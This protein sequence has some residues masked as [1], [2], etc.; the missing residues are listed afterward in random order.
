MYAIQEAQ[1]SDEIV[2]NVSLQT[3]FSSITL[4]HSSTNLSTCYS[5]TL[6][7]YNPNILLCCIIYH[8]HTDNYLDSK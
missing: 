8:T 2:F 7:F 6:N 1:S 5:C 4:A 3:L